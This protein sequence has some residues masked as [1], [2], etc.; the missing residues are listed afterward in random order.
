MSEIRF[1]DVHLITGNPRKIN[2]NTPAAT[3]PHNL[4]RLY[5]VPAVSSPPPLHYSWTVSAGKIV[6]QDR[7]QIW[8]QATADG[9]VLVTCTIRNSTTGQQLQRK[10]TLTIKKTMEAF[11]LIRGDYVVW[12][13]GS[14]NMTQAVHLPTR[15]LKTLGSGQAQGFDGVHAVA[16]SPK[17]GDH[18]MLVYHVT[19]GK[20]TMI[21]TPTMKAAWD[22]RFFRIAG[23]RI[24]W[25]N[26]NTSYTQLM[27]YTM[28]LG[29]EKET[30]IHGPSLVVRME[31]DV[32]SRRL[33]F[34][35]SPLT[36]KY[37]IFNHIYDP[38]TN[39]VTARPDL[40]AMGLV[41]GWADPWIVLQDVSLRALY[42][43]STK[44]QYKITSKYSSLVSLR[45]SSTH[46]GGHARNAFGSTGE[47]FIVSLVGSQPLRVAVNHN[48]FM[49]PSMDRGRIV[50]MHQGDIFLL[51]AK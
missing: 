24:Y 7:H 37:K 21:S 5:V 13:S 2:P 50:Y 12:S 30:K 15:K 18:A 17:F 41:E 51:T 25:A 20:K 33:A 38:T 34:T 42:N 36:G 23:Q 27:L 35:T 44:Q 47:I 9:K 1:E 49:M 48:N 14:P 6:K 19:S 16:R 4:V 40:D 28:L 3:E 31:L 11:P 8:F 46:Y 32:N 26:T 29:Q 45:V 10:L 43:R 39:K 22:H